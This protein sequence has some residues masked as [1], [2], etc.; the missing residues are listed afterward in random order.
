MCRKA[1]DHVKNWENNCMVSRAK[2]TNCRRQQSSAPSLLM[3]SFVWKPLPVLKCMVSSC[4]SFLLTE[5]CLSTTW[6][7]AEPFFHTAALHIIESTFM[8]YVSLLFSK[9]KSPQLCHHHA[10]HL[11]GSHCPLGAVWIVTPIASSSSW[12]NAQKRNHRSV[13]WGLRYGGAYKSQVVLTN[14]TVAFLCAFSF[15]GPWTSGL[16]W[17]AWK[18]GLMG[19]CVKF[20]RTH[21]LPS[22]HFSVGGAS[23]LPRRTTTM[24]SWS[25]K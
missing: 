14:D 16:P 5:P 6:D 11:S 7:N 18:C 3:T 21:T 25:R 15:T 8:S 20:Q 10:V 19:I 24:H 1:K 22:G 2:R 9:L 12:R 17:W 4:L 23:C 13:L